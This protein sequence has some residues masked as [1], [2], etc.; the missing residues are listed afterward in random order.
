MAA[1]HRVLLT[2]LRSVFV[3]RVHILF[4]RLFCIAPWPM[5]AS[6]Q[7]RRVYFAKSLG[8][9]GTARSVC[10][11]VGAAILFFVMLSTATAEPR[12]VLLLHAFGHP[13]SPWSDMAASFRAALIKR[14]PEPIDLFEVSLDTA[15]V[16]DSQ[17]EGPFVEY[18]RALLSR[19]KLDLIVPV[20]APAAFFMQ[21]HRPLLFPSTPMLIVGADVRRIPNTSLTENDT[22][23]LLDLDL[24]AYL[25]NVVR[26]RPETTDI[27]VV[28]GNSPVERF[29]TSELRR[30]FK[31]LADRVNITWFNDLTFGEML[32]RAATMPPQS[33][34]FWFLLSEDAAGVPYSQDRALE[35]MREVATVPIFGMGDYELGRGIVG[36]P[37]MQTQVLGEE[38]VAVG[39]RILRGETPGGI[40]RPHVGFGAP[41]YD[42]R[43]LRRWGIS[44][45]RLPPGSIV[46]FRE[47]MVWKQYR[48]QI[49][50]IVA[51]ILAQTLL[52]AY[53]LFQNRRR[54][55]AEISLKEAEKRMTFTAASANVGLWQFNRE[56]NELWATEHCRAMFGLASDVP[57]TR[58]TFLAAI[59]PED[60]ET[61]ISSLREALKPNQSAVADVRVVLPDDQ[62][63][64]I[65]IRARLHPDD[66][67]APNKL[68]GIFVDMTDQKAAEAEAALQHQEVAHLKRASVLG[69]LSG[70]IAHEINQPLTAILSNAQGA[71]HLLAK[72]SPDL[73]E[74]RDALQ[75]IVLADNRA[76]EVVHRLH[77]LL[78]KGEAK[79]ESVDVNDLA[80][81]TIALLNSELI[82]RGI[83]VKVDLA[84]G[85]PATSGD[86]VQL[87]QVLLNLVM[88]AMDAMASTPL[89]QRT[90]TVSTRTTRTGAVEVLVKDRGRGIRPAE[91]SRLFEPFYTTKSHGLGLGLTICSTIVQAH[92]GKL[93]L[94]NDE[95]GGVRVAF[96]LPAQ[97]TLVA[98]K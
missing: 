86:V 93:T 85:L 23:V 26:L 12:R 82:S 15:R 63:R 5:A 49:I 77:N 90:I 37:L 68:S 28:V 19:R 92:G 78:R 96:S 64:W 67:A 41:M 40:K 22:A 50:L 7:W 88:N 14:S 36:G 29:W 51:T 72:N 61:A 75:D 56:T 91:Q 33:A 66:R 1:Y 59:H 38:A 34:I 60:R 70:A 25:E 6:D 21:R 2:G 11:S 65:R 79:F 46:Q 73:A 4:S 35:T 9:S 47:P 3:A 84:N 30:D 53:V 89:A 24:P 52:I 17:D 44:E 16:Q 55:A 31:P 58:D 57:L 95:A 43:E 80:N 87:Q 39:L 48:W 71:L 10:A 62:V 69:Q 42:W 74:V 98:A 45:A 8:A 20:G 18:I 13:F 54:R 76:S 81:S 97:E 32:T 94:A 83:N 27:G